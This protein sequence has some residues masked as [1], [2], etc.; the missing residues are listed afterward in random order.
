MRHTPSLCHSVPVSNSPGFCFMSPA[1]PFCAPCTPGS[2]CQQSCLPSSGPP[3][4]L[5][6]RGDV[7]CCDASKSPHCGLVSPCVISA[8]PPLQTLPTPCPRAPVSPNYQPFLNCLGSPALHDLAQAA[9]S[10]WNFL[11]GLS[12]TTRV[13]GVL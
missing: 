10:A 7:R 13:E 12:I 9:S 8:R 5:K 1:P 4:G 2:A 11:P 3:C 6:L